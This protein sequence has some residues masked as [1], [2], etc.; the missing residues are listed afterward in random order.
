VNFFRGGGK[1][2][3]DQLIDNVGVVDVSY[4]EKVLY[5]ICRRR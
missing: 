3:Q 4:L 2:A 1:F 5:D